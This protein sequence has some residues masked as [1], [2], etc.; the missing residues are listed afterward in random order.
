MDG[1]EVNAPTTELTLMFPDRLIIHHL[2]IISRTD[3]RTYT[4]RCT[5]ISYRE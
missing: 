1:T 2:D 5:G 3:I 4:T